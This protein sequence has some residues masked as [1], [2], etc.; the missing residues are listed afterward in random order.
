MIVTGSPAPSGAG[1]PVRCCVE[2]STVAR[3]LS[4]FARRRE[5]VP[6]QRMALR[7]IK[8]VIRLKW[9]AQLA[10]ESIATA[11]GVSK[12]VVTKYIGLC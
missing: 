9:E 1:L 2:N 5:T 6:K 3:T 4:G 12:G 11:L 7:M 8:D 10:H